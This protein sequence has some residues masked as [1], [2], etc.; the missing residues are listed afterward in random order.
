MIQIFGRGST[1]YRAEL[2]QCRNT[3]WLSLQG[4]TCFPN[5]GTIKKY[6]LVLLGQF[7]SELPTDVRMMYEVLFFPHAQIQDDFSNSEIIIDQ[8][9]SLILCFIKSCK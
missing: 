2:S 4:K 1:E 8:R 3:V 5:R 6:N 7:K 9:C